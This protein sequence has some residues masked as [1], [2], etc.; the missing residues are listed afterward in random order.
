MGNQSNQRIL[1]KRK[2]FQE[3]LMEDG[4]LFYL[5]WFKYLKL[6]HEISEKNTQIKKNLQK[7][8]EFYRPLGNYLK[9][10]FNEIWKEKNHLFW[11]D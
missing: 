8:K 11:E 7:S 2:D 10:D 3:Y 4:K 6:S 1:N 9:K 5:T